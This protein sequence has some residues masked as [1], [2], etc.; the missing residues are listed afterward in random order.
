MTRLRVGSPL[1]KIITKRPGPTYLQQIILYLFY[2]ELI[3]KD[4]TTTREIT[5]DIPMEYKTANTI[6]HRMKAYEYISG[7]KTAVT[8]YKTIAFLDHEVKEIT[9]IGDEQPDYINDA[10]IIEMKRKKLVLWKLTK[11]G[12]RYAKHIWFN[13]DKYGLNDV[14]LK[15][16]ISALRQG[17]KSARL[18]SEEN[19]FIEKEKEEE[20]IKT[21][22]PEENDDKTLSQITSPFQKRDYIIQKYFTHNNVVSF[23]NINSQDG[24]DYKIFSPYSGWRQLKIKHRNDNEEG[25]VLNKQEQDFLKND[26]KNQLLV[27]SSLSDNVPR[28]IALIS[29]E[30]VHKMD[31]P[32]EMDRYFK[33]RRRDFDDKV[34]KI[35]ERYQ[36]PKI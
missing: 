34:R 15:Y 6:L 22:D 10:E 1:H 23:P 31:D 2:R 3:D 26:S 21:E 13:P 7:R 8:N 33:D 36:R 14:Q 25:I 32:I 20:V 27:L 5:D 11:G 9:I 4:V 16:T 12:R 19:D 24:A 28:I 35:S 29:F 18:S 17:N 30:Y